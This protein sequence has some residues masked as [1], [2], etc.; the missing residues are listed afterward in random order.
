MADLMRMLRLP[1]VVEATGMSS[2]TIWRREKNGEFPRRRRLGANIV[3]WRSDEIKAFIEGLPLADE[4]SGQ[5]SS[6]AA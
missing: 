4:E 2:T 5:P 3:A 1:D 6:D